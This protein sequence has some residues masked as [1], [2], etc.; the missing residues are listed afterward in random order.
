MEMK[1][2]EG[3]EDELFRGDDRGGSIKQLG[4]AFFVA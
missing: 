2:W 3:S 1:L 4:R